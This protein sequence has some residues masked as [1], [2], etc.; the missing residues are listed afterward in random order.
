MVPFLFLYICE[1]KNLFLDEK[2][3]NGNLKGMSVTLDAVNHKTRMMIELDGLMGDLEELNKLQAKAMGLLHMPDED[4]CSAS[5]DDHEDLMGFRR[6]A[7]ECELLYE[8]QYEL[9]LHY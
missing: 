9:S 8:L 7:T 2:N 4:P 3:M 1:A 6:K 5:V